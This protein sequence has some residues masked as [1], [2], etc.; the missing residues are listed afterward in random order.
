MAR[1]IASSACSARSCCRCRSASPSR[2]AAASACR[3]QLVHSAAPAAA[4]SSRTCG[5][6]AAAA[7]AAAESPSKAADD[8]PMSALDALD[9][10]SPAK[11]KTSRGGK[12]M[13]KRKK[14]CVM[15]LDMPALEP[16]KYPTC[17]LRRSVRISPTS[18]STLYITEPD[19]EWF[20]DW[21]WGEL[22]TGG[23]TRAEETFDDLEPHCVAAGVLIRPEF[24]SEDLVY[25][26]IVLEG[27]R[28]GKV[29]KS[30]VA[31][32]TAS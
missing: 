6:G 17:A 31:G 32:M 19:L 20:L 27:E 24:T 7:E 8:D 30:A 29:V 23:I 14:H 25:D 22:E 2:A 28:K 13:S 12:Y 3:R 18:T 10:E 4:C 21:V 9:G 16:T 11:A 26:V 15:V 5:Q 1:E